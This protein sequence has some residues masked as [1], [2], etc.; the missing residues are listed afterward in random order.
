MKLF[1]F[2]LIVVWNSLAWW[3]KASP[4]DTSIFV[5]IL[6]IELSYISC[7]EILNSK[8]ELCGFSFAPWSPLARRFEH[9]VS[10][11]ANFKVYSA[12]WCTSFFWFLLWPPPQWEVLR[13][14][15]TILPREELHSSEVLRSGRPDGC[16]R[17]IERPMRRTLVHYFLFALYTTLYSERPM[18]FC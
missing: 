18:Y 5:T 9:S 6:T 8:I 12:Q 7:F 16:C 4:Y 3:V 15:P 2:C 17:P 1:L 14:N 13:S 10:S 11:F